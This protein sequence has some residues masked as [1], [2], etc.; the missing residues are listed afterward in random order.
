MHPSC[1]YRTSVIWRIQKH[2]TSFH[3]IVIRMYRRGDFAQLRKGM[4]NFS[5]SDVPPN[6]FHRVRHFRPLVDRPVLTSSRS[7]LLTVS[8]R[9]G[10]SKTVMT[11]TVALAKA[12]KIERQKELMRPNGV[13]LM[14]TL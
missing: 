10:I 5:G 4:P 14:E 8:T 13:N 12:E 11:T 3:R 1:S 2:R 9:E 6:G 7:G